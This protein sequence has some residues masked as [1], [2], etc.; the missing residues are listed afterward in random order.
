MITLGLH[1]RQMEQQLAENAVARSFVEC[2]DHQWPQIRDHANIS[3]A[4]ETLGK[5]AQQAINDC[6]LHTATHFGF[7]IHRSL[8]ETPQFRKSLLAIPMN[9]EF[10][11]AWLSG[12]REL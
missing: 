10:S 3:R 11:R 2:Q 5:E 4:Y 8:V 6:V 9:L 7:G 12:V 1:S